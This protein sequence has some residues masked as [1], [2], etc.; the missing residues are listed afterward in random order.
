MTTV[1]ELTIR[2]ESARAGTSAR[3]PG[4]S[5][6]SGGSSPGWATTPP[7]T[8]CRST[9]LPIRL[10]PRVPPA[11]GPDGA[12]AAPRQPAHQVPA[13]R[14]GRS[15]AGRGRQRRAP[16]GDPYVLARRPRRSVPQCSPSWLGAPS[17]TRANGR[18]G[19]AWWRVRAWR[20][21]WKRPART[22]GWTTGG[23]EMAKAPRPGVD[24]VRGDRRKGRCAWLA[25]ALQPLEA[26]EVQA[27][28]LGRR[29]DEA[30]RRYWSEQLT[31]GPRQDIRSSP[32]RLE[33]RGR[34]GPSCSPTRCCVRPR[35]HD[36]FVERAAELE[37]SDAAVLLL[38]RPSHQLARMSG[39]SEVLFQ[40]VVGNRF[41][42]AA[43]ARSVR[44]RRRPCSDSRTRTGTSGRGSTADPVRR[45]QR[46]P[47]SR[48]TTS[49][50]WT[51]RS[52]NW[53][54]RARRPTTVLV[55]RHP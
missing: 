39:S 7:G 24:R 30:A 36:R 53:S 9:S 44:R 19:S 34:S 43:A 29:R 54:R 49:G 25:P 35:W 31:A 8:T 5:G 23:W 50:R 14:R 1:N 52:R 27:S 48:P 45:V 42:P 32:R 4:G 18:C 38:G 16:G 47:P 28:P 6:R 22:P 12:A 2:L 20:T 10:K 40:V 15:G 13:D 33:P 51:G 3:R 17:T 26:A 41:Q 55:E 11:R 37:V 46:V 21:G